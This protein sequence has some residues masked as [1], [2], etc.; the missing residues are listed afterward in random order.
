VRRRAA[1]T[2]ALVVLL[3]PRFAIASSSASVISHG[4]RS[5]RTIALTFDDGWGVTNCAKVVGILERTATPATFFPSAY[6]VAAAPTFWH[7]V[8]DLGFPFANH[9]VNHPRM[10]K[11]SSA[12][13]IRQ[14]TTARTTIEKII[15]QPMLRLFRPP[16][17]SYNA[18]TRA[19][20][21][22]AG[23]PRLLLWDTTFADSARRPNG[24]LWPLSSY[25]RSAT[26][27]QN[28][29]II[30]GHCGSSIDAAILASVIT[31]YRNRGFVFVTL[32]ELLHLPGALPMH[33]PT[34]TAP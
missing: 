26:K 7:H 12:A 32:P 3:F 30:L 19:A 33:F 10:T 25:R 17:G 1:L 23:F 34:T 21:A 27:G 16:Y 24:G 11:L 2:V 20:A 9:G 29:S 8:A 28:G 13:Q 31:D 14:I 18:V 15:G 4:D 22:T 5:T 6:W